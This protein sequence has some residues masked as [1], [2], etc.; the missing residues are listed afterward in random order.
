MGLTAEGV[1]LGS[2]VTRLPEQQRWT[3]EGWSDLKGLPWDLKPEA[4]EAPIAVQGT[5]EPAP[6]VVTRPEQQ[7][8]DSVPKNLC[9]R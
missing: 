2:G 7:P 9:S 3:L 4:R 5:G 1:K 8:E 6:V